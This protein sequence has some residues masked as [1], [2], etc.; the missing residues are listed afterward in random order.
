MKGLGHY[1]I[2]SFFI[3]GVYFAAGQVLFPNEKPIPEAVVLALIFGLTLQL[4]NTWKDRR[5]MEGKAPLSPAAT[6]AL[7][8]ISSGMAGWF[9]LCAPPPPTGFEF[10]AMLVLTMLFLYVLAFGIR[11]AWRTRRAGGTSGT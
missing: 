9:W 8:A 3:A 4:F 10:Y 6:I 2:M 5:V 7:G 11:L 1:L